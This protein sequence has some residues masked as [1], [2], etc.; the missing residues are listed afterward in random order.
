MLQVATTQRVADEKVAEV[1]R[2]LA[3]EYHQKLELQR[4]HFCT[5][6]DELKG[7]ADY[8]K[9]KLATAEGCGRAMVDARAM[10]EAEISFLHLQVEGVS[11][12]VEKA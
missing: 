5:W 6:R 10:A 12:L 8:L 7:K 3:E 9:E 1:C 2:S 4:A 11:S